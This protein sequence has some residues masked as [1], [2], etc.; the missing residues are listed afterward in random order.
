MIAQLSDLHVGAGDSG[1]PERDA[2]AA[3]RRLTHV[4]GRADALLISG[5]LVEHGTP[6]EY[7]RVRELLADVA[8]PVL[9]LPGNHDDRAAL[10][11][12][13]PELEAYGASERGPLHYAVSH[14]GMRLVACDSSVSGQA[15]GAL[16]EE[17]LQ[18]LEDE[19]ARCPAAPTLVAL[20]HP[21]IA[22]GM[23]MLDEIA[24]AAADRRAL[25][26][27]LGRH[28][29]VKGVVCGHTHFA[30]VALL[31]RCPVTTCPSTWRVRAGLRLH[32][33]GYAL[34]TG[35]AGFMVHL[36]TA[37]GITS[38]VQTFDPSSP[39]ATGATAGHRERQDSAGVG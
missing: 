32:D 19:L 33:D 23:P 38:H 5:D 9:P 6:A 7:A 37:G 3:L 17:Q 11:A 15:Y 12:A 34:E 30:S 13:F 28:S 39:D 31:G 25:G 20:H 36:T 26:G 2:V 18:W 10:R 24:L 4:A 35:P 16:G 8:V 22:T 27:V 1:D 14:G 21:P 29:H